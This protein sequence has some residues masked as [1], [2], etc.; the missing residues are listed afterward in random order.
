MYISK[1]ISAK[2]LH[3]CKIL[4]SLVKY[5]VNIDLNVKCILYT[6]HVFTCMFQVGG[7]IVDLIDHLA[8]TLKGSVIPDR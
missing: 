6:L 1:K 8:A 3:V 5:N 4:S 7:M 2:I